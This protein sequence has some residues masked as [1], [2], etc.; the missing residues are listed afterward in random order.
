[1]ITLVLASLALGMGPQPPLHCPGTLEAIDGKPAGTFEYNGSVFGTCCG[2][3]EKPFEK[4]PTALIAKA[5][6]A[7]KTVGAFGYDPVSGLKIDAAKAPA[8]TDYKAIRY[9]F[10]TAAEK[11]AFDANPAK[12]VGN[13]KSEAYFCPVMKHATEAGK[14]GAFA[15]YNGVRYYTCCGDCLKAFKANPAKYAANAK[16]AVKPLAVSTL[17]Q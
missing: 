17:K 1:M 11:K 9:A 5:A 13:V 7:N 4:N 16:A 8:Y 14:A 6:K 10:A 3:C 12:Y 15:D 2:G